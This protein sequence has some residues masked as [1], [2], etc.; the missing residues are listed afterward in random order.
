MEN[1]YKNKDVFELDHLHRCMVNFYTPSQNTGW[2]Q[3]MFE[4][5][6]YSLLYYVNDADG[7]TKFEDNDGKLLPNWKQSLI[8]YMK[9]FGMYFRIKTDE[10]VQEEYEDQQM[11]RNIVTRFKQVRNYSDMSYIHDA[12]SKIFKHNPNREPEDVINEIRKQFDIEKD[13]ASGK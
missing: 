11:G 4:E 10:E 9:K 6:Y 1:I 3:D 5:G 13:E 12:L 2:H 7:G 8:N